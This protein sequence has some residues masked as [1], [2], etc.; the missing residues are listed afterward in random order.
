[1]SKSVAPAAMLEMEEGCR[2]ALQGRRVAG[3]MTILQPGDLAGA[4]RQRRKGPIE[5][6]EIS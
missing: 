3:V 6:A 1:V 5:Y 4:P 2:P